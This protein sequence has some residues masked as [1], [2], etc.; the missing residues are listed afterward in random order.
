MI[1]A[2]EIAEKFAQ[3]GT[4][5]AEYYYR[6]LDA[7][8]R[9]NI[10]TLYFP[11]ALLTYEDKKVKGHE[12][13]HLTFKSLGFNQIAHKTTTVDC[14]PLPDGILIV[15]NGQLQADAEHPM[16]FCQTF[17]IRQHPTANWLVAHDIFRLGVH[18]FAPS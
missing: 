12:G 2:A 13:I 9:E 10:Y 18:N 7:G 11:D 14:H 15:C 17:I 1:S 16:P 4:Q 3:I 8:P 5:F 6:C